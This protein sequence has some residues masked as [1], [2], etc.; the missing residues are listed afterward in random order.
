VDPLERASAAS[1]LLHPWV[2]GE[3]KV[4]PRLEVVPRLGFMKHARHRSL[5]LTSSADISLV[6][7]EMQQFHMDHEALTRAR[8][9]TMSWGNSLPRMKFATNSTIPT[10]LSRQL[11]DFQIEEVKKE[12][13]KQ[14]E[15]TPSDDK[16]EGKEKG[17]AFFKVRALFDHTPTKPREL[18]FEQGEEFIMLEKEE[19]L[20]WGKGI[21]PDGTS[22]WFPLSYLEV[23]AQVSR[24]EVEFG[25][26]QLLLS[27]EDNTTPNT[28]S[29]RRASLRPRRGQFLKGSSLSLRSSNRGTH[30]PQKSPLGLSY[31]AEK[32]IDREPV[33]ATVEVTSDDM[34]KNEDS[35]DQ[36]DP[37]T[38]EGEFRQ[39]KKN[40]KK[41]NRRRREEEHRA[42][43]RRTRTT[44]YY[45]CLR[46]N[47]S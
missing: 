9:L 5:S 42:K 13:E 18:R 1:A 29:S 7:D 19:D 43:R 15:T 44:T 8:H 37:L 46:F 12:R 47:G 32:G 17:D 36:I 22:G 3:K 21:K 26:S 24:E 4:R 14:K 25:D 6:Q 28:D 20:G 33:F 31:S 38:G 34:L 40:R 10:E 23:V 27:A 35:D 39:Q 11:R 41:K 16:E 30:S 2:T 45:F